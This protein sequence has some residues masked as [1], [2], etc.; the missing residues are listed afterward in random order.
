M[1]RDPQQGVELDVITRPTRRPRFVANIIIESDTCEGPASAS[2]SG[3]LSIEVA[4]FGRRQRE[5]DLRLIF[6]VDSLPENRWILP[7]VCHGVMK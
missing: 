1:Q 2:G 5:T 4:R 3:G 7:S 6:M